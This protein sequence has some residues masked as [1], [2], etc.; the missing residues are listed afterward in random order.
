MKT[1]KGQKNMEPEDVTVYV[2]QIP[3]SV[4]IDC[5][6]CE[7]SIDIDYDEFCEQYDNKHL[8]V[9]RKPTVLTVG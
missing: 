3:V 7:N 6:A 9:S 8:T 4:S 5:P 2:H 1:K